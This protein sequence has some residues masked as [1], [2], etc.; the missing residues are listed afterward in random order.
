MMRRI[1]RTGLVVA[2]EV[3]WLVVAVAIVA[4]GVLGF[5]YL[6]AN[7]DVV[8]AQPAERP[9]ALVET[10]ALTRHEGPLPIRGEGFV[11]PI[12]QVS[13]S[14]QASGL[15][16]RVHP[17]IIDRGAFAEGDLLVQIDDRAQQTTLT[18][19]AANIAA[20]EARLGQ[21]RDD[22]AR[23]EAL[24]QRQV[25][26]QTQV[27]QLRSQITELEAT[28]DGLRAARAAAEIEI[29]DRRIRAP[30]DG[31][32]LSKAV[33]VGDV[34]AAGQV[35]AEAF[36]PDKLEVD[37]AIRQADAA[38]IPGL[39][40]GAAPSARIDIP[41][42]NETFLWSGHIDRVEPQLDVATRT[43]TAAVRLDALLGAEGGAGALAS[44]APPALINA[45][46]NVVIDGAERDN[47]YSVPSVAVRSG[48]RLWLS[49]AGVLRILP[50][51]RVHVDGE[52]SFVEIA[53]APADAAVVFTPLAA[54]V[55]GMALRDVAE[56]AERASL[57][58][59]A[60][61]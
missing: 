20:S 40:A 51:R 52:W 49:D 32:I 21:L 46:A 55:P 54:P 45:F 18:Q 24:F 42:G 16:T 7:R 6:G 2:R 35:L 15:V 57:E 5:Q 28:L 3:F 9:V 27:D 13:V 23:T 50:A 1:F 47:I 26:T 58:T 19:T 8:E 14:A 4:G 59:G 34:V 44:G 22:L 38:L 11:V 36:T 56:T 33:E 12:R 37:I 10:G 25:A 30:F 41:F 53:D 60:L 39:F 17:A 29:E 43:L 31:A 61:Q 48:D